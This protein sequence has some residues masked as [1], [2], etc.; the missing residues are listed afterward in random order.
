MENTTASKAPVTAKTTEAAKTETKTTATSAATASSAAEKKT[1]PAKKSAAK[2]PAAKKPAAKKAPAKTAAAKKTTTAKAPAAKKAA[3]KRGR[4]PGSKNKV[5]ES[6]QETIVQVGGADLVVTETLVDR[7]KDK[8]K[9][10]GHRV[11]NIKSL[12]IY[13]NVDERKA[14]YVIN[15]NSDDNSFIDL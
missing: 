3:P 2:K 9:N 13:I 8:Y 7:V 4:K 11:G 14:Y 5:V 15:G 12:Q 10:E 1:A 6:I